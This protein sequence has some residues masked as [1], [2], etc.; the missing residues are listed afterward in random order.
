MC[1]SMMD[2]AAFSAFFCGDEPES[3]SFALVHGGDE[4][5]AAVALLNHRRNGHTCQPVIMNAI[6]AFDR[7]SF[8]NLLSATFESSAV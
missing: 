8:P 5:R 7:L 3:E 6:K 2:L 4:Q 1:L